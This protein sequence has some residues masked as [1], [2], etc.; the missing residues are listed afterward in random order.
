M[1]GS[2]SNKQMLPKRAQHRPRK[3]IVVGCKISIAISETITIE[4]ELLCAIGRTEAQGVLGVLY[5]GRIDAQPSFEVYFISWMQRPRTI[6][7]GERPGHRIAD[8]T[9][10][11]AIQPLHLDHQVVPIF[12]A[13]RVASLFGKGA[14][15]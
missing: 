7:D 9:H 6:G 3:Y 11:V 8:L 15:W 1:L 13:N 12:G 2:G 10:L 4:I 14:I 5:F